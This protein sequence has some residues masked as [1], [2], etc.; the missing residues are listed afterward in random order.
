M[1]VQVIVMEST[2]KSAI[3]RDPLL[4]LLSIRLA[5]VSRSLGL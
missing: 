1:A 4:Y 3:S 5:E 2:W